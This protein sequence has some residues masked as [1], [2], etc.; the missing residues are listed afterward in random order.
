MTTFAVTDSFEAN[1]SRTGCGQTHINTLVL[2]VIR[3]RFFDPFEHPMPGSP[4]RLTLGEKTIEGKCDENAWIDIRIIDVPEKATI[5]WGLVD[6]DE[7][8]IPQGRGY[9]EA[10]DVP[11]DE[12]GV[13]TAA[14]NS[15]DP[16]S[17]DSS[18][19]PADQTP[20]MNYLYAREIH[21]VFDPQPEQ[22]TLQRLHNLGYNVWQDLEQNVRAFQLTYQQSLTGRASDIEADL[23]GWHDDCSPDPFPRLDLKQNVQ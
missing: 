1:V 14:T 20:T 23:W 9:P 18:A 7:E 15:A 16:K 21:L 2:S 11:V 17:A 13:S 4:F 8:E 22:A 5:E 19:A 12:Q 6:A 10:D 3:I